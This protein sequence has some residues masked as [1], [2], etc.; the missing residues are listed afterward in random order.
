MGKVELLL[1]KEYIKQ[2]CGSS[3]VYQRGLQYFQ[4]GRVTSL[5]YHPAE[6]GWTATVAGSDDYNVAI[7]FYNE[8]IA[9]KCDCPAY[10]EYL[11][12][13]HIVAV[14]LEVQQEIQNDTPKPSVA[15]SQKPAPAPIPE[16]A[17]SHA[18]HKS[19]YDLDPRRY[20]QANRIINAFVNLP[21]PAKDAKQADDKQPL[22]VEYICRTQQAGSL[23][24]NFISIELKVGTNRTYVVK[25]IGKFLQSIE[26]KTACSFTNHFTYDPLEHFFMEEDREILQL[27]QQIQKNE[28]FFHRQRGYY[29]NYENERSVLIPPMLANEFFSKLQGRN[30]YFDEHRH[31]MFQSNPDQLPLIFRLEKG[32]EGEFQLDLS[33]LKKATFFEPYGWLLAD[34]IIYQLSAAQ[35]EILSELAPYMKPF[36]G[37][38]VPVARKQMETFVSYVMPGLKKIGNMQ[39]AEEVSE[40]IINLPLQA[41]VWIDR[42][43]QRLL[44]KIEYHYGNIV[45]DPF[46]LDETT[47]PTQANP[48]NPVNPQ[49]SDT[50]LTRETDKEREIMKIFENNTFKYNGKE[51]YLTGDDE[52]YDFLFSAVPY[53]EQKAE[54]YMTSAVKSLILPMDNRPVTQIDVDTS[55]NLLEISFDMEGI[56]QR[57]VSQ[58]LQSVVEKKKYYRLPSGAFVSLQDEGFTTIQRLLSELHI[59]KSQIN[60]DVL[61]IP[62]YRGLLIDDII[63]EGDK[64]AAKL[65]KKFRRLIQ[66]LKN[67]DVLDFALPENLQG[68]LRDYQQ[69]GFQWLKTLAHYRL[70]GILAD[71]MGLGKTL[72][73]IAYL[74]SEKADRN[75]EIQMASDS[76]H[77]SDDSP[78]PPVPPASLIVVPASLVYNWKSEFARFAP[79]LDVEVV[80]GTP[81]ERRESFRDRRPDVLITSYPLLRQDLELYESMEFD[82][83]ILDEAQ[84]IKNHTTKTANAVKKI[85][86]AKRFALSGTPI[87]NSLDELWSIFDAILPGFFLNQ[88]TFRN[89]AQDK[90]ARMVRPFILR[91]VKNDVLKELP[92]KIETVHQS[93]LTK[94]QKELYVGYLEKIQQE[95]MVSLQTEGFD[96]SRIKILAGLTRLRQLCCH[97][98]LFLENYHGQSGK[99]EQLMEIIENALA[100]KKR[101][102]VFSQFT[103][104]LQI[105]RAELERVNCGYFYLDGQTPAKER[106]EMTE[107]FNRGE[108][109]LFLISLKAGGTGLNLTGADTVILYDLWWNPAVEEQ[110]AG[111]AHRIGQK[112]VVQVMRLIAR[113]TIE[114]KIYQM[115]QKK[116][117]LIEQVIQPGERML[118]SLSEAEIR[119]ILG[120]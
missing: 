5:D 117:E 47:Q 55:G 6:D 77:A 107:R 97:P 110:A 76:S 90:I 44:A 41:K 27:L 68:K 38:V 3:A 60:A 101:L 49:A 20:Q 111:R 26:E 17:A 69:F 43:D 19:L 100:N 29:W 35:K 54:I 113:G 24:Q 87:E 42:Q 118:T 57:E 51:C 39:L 15:E 104:M 36:R 12:C 92:A 85:R 71:D 116:K 74:L 56:D 59:N 81:E 34:G 79:D 8:L 82:S 4:Q 115:Q 2:W 84:A 102:L 18:A 95:A 98:A 103:S 28:E 40:Q 72:Q 14:L 22:T 106:L 73:A 67:P 99:L 64:Y 46:R 25:K 93:E 80:Y 62:L 86:A 1:T 50:I 91:R 112:N 109:D 45:I 23:R 9:A 89:L 48:T 16:T 94:K 7:H 13:K 33:P 120:I 70:G 108:K 65:G 83:L 88:R 66:D 105:I 31:V 61:Q 11:A 63:S 37:S 10:D 96:K 53:L 52:I 58:I 119:E 30:M 75:K 21:N 32:A 78:T 114:E